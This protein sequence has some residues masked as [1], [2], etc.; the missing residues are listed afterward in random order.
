[1]RLDLISHQHKHWVV[2]KVDTIDANNDILID[3]NNDILIDTND[4]IVIDVAFCAVLI[5]NCPQRYQVFTVLF[6]I[7]SDSFLVA[8]SVRPWMRDLSC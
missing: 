2:M 5:V 4:D 6:W 8:T 7:I 1:M 3:A